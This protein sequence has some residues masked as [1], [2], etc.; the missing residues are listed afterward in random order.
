MEK[1]KIIIKDEVIYLPETSSIM[2]LKYPKEIFV[3][4]YL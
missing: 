3:S 4:T 1:D 2:T